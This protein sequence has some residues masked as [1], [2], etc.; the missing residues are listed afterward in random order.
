MQRTRRA[1]NNEFRL[2]IIFLPFF[3]IKKNP[4]IKHPSTITE[5]SRHYLRDWELEVRN[6]KIETKDEEKSHTKQ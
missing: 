5:E 1:P 4:K 3:E 6:E 2:Q